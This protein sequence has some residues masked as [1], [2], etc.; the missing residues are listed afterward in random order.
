MQIDLEGPYEVALTTFQYTR[1]WNN[2]TS[3][4]SGIKIS[5]NGLQ[6]ET[7]IPMGFY[8]NESGLLNVIS[9][10][11]VK[12]LKKTSTCNAEMRGYLASCYAHKF[13]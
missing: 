4:S 10:S 2:V 5:I 3:D 11:I 9:K 13:F 7:T 12:A 1:S 8:E 6:M